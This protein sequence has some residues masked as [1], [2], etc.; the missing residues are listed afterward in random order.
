MTAHVRAGVGLTLLLAGLAMFGP[1]AIDTVFPAFEVMRREFEVDSTAMQQITSAYLASFAVM[2]IFHG[3]LSD[4]LGRKPVMLTGIAVFTLASVGAALAPNLSVLLACRVV[5]GMSAGAGQIVSRTVIRDLFHGAYAQRLMAQVAMI[6]GLAPALAPVIGGYLLAIGPW[7]VIFWSL[8]AF[9][10]VIGLATFFVLP[11]TLPP[12]HRVPLHVGALLR[13]VWIVG[14][15][16][17]FARL[18][19]ATAL[20][21]ATQFLYIAAAPIFVVDLLGKGERDFWIFFFPMIGGLM[22]GS[23]LTARTAGIV[24]AQRMATYGIVLTLIGGALN[25]ALMATDLPS[26]P[27]AIVGPTALTVGVAAA[28]PIL[29]LAFLDMHPERR[30]TCASVGMCVSFVFNALLAGVVAPVATESL[31]RLAAVS[32]G[33]GVLGALLWWWHVRARPESAPAPRGE[34]PTLPV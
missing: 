22:L 23:W 8:A 24:P 18:A 1:F 19:I 33:F 13:S 21:F 12:E 7:P 26:L 28:F 17:A 5:Q 31:V 30:G 29:Q 10:L 20:I 9:G 3:P 32:L 15:D 2:T 11:E 14:S 25:V 16:G 27:W 4:A 34:T 6:F